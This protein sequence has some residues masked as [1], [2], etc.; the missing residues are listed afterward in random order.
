MCTVQVDDKH[1]D[2]HDID[3]GIISAFITLFGSLWFRTNFNL[4]LVILIQI[5]II[6]AS[7]ISVS[8]RYSNSYYYYYHG[9]NDEQGDIIID[10]NNQLNEFLYYCYTNK[11]KWI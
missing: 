9:I 4:N 10:D 11:Y 2:D 8:T 7:C 6:Y 1:G 5:A 3:V